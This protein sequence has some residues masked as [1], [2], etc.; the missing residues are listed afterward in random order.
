MPVPS[1]RVLVTPATYASATPGCSIGK[2]GEAGEGGACG[3]GSTTCSPVPADSK[4]ASSS[5]RATRAETCGS[6][7]GPEPIPK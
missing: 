2:R 7:Q 1:R 4:P 6:A 5:A 3:S